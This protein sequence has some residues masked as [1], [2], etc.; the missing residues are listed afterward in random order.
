MYDMRTSIS[1]TTT[2]EYA[3]RFREEAKSL[4]ISNREMFDKM[5]DSYFLNKNVEA[6]TKPKVMG[7]LL[8][9]NYA[10][11]NMKGSKP[12]IIDDGSIF[13]EFELLSH[14]THLE[15][16]INMDSRMY[17]YFSIEYG[18]NIALPETKMYQCVNLYRIFSAQRLFSNKVKDDGNNGRIVVNIVTEV[19]YK[20][21]SRLRSEKSIFVST[22]EEILDAIMNN[23]ASNK[24]I[25]EIEKLLPHIDI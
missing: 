3:S 17:D 13:Y 7:L 23:G 22:K 19:S 14:H 11:I 4:G 18:V 5:L 21:S 6:N 9:K 12:T 1:V 15:R 25:E 20:M 2:E 10:R 16:I 8:K 24:N